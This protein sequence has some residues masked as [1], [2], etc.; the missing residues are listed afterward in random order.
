MLYDHK[1]RRTTNVHSEEELHA[2][3]QQG[4]RK[5]AFLREATAASKRRAASQTSAKPC[6]IRKKND[7]LEATRLLVMQMAKEGYSQLDMCKQLGDHARPPHAAWRVLTWPQAYLKY[8][9][10]VKK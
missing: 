10:A 4:W 7:Q 9:T 1:N 2:H 5:D 6:R 3:L 8:Q